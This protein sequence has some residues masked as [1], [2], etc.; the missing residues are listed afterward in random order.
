MMRVADDRLEAANYL[1]ESLGGSL[2]SAHWEV[3]GRAVHAI[4]DLP[5]SSAA[6]AVAAV[7]SQSAAFKNVDVQEVLTQAQF[8]G[9][10]ELAD[11][12][13]QVYRLPGQAAL[14]DDT[15]RSVSRQRT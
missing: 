6:T 2:Q 7:F 8:T 13:K 9:S 11:D 5:D 1:M 3:S 14:E 10:L 12:S 4:V 15:S